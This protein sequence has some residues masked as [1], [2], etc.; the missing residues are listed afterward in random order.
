MSRSHSHTLILQDDFSEVPHGE[1]RPQR[2]NE[3]ILRLVCLI[4]QE[5][6]QSDLVARPYQDVWLAVEAPVE[7]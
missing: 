5:I 1:I 7:L 6:A 2:L 4:E 3:V